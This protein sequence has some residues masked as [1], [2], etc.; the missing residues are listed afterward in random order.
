MISPTICQLAVAMAGTSLVLQLASAV[1]RGSRSAEDAS[2]DPVVVTPAP[3]FSTITGLPIRPIT[4]SREWSRSSL[5]KLR[6]HHKV[7][8]AEWRA[9]ARK[10]TMAS[11][12]ISMGMTHG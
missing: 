1:A 3:A 8:S 10:G 7:H 9:Y 6:R 2:P 4:S 11:A 12:L 5:A